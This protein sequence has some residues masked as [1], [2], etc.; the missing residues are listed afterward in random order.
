MHPLVIGLTLS[1][2]A[3]HA[4]WNALLRSG[5]DRL[6]S[7]TVM[8]FATTVA[9]VP[10]ALIL[11]TPLPECWPYIA[12]SA[13]LQ[14][15]YSILLASAYRHGELGQVYPIVRGSVPVLV[16][17]A[18]FLLASQTLSRLGLLGIALVSAGIAS[19]ALGRPP[20]TTKTLLLALATALFVAS[21]V[22]ADGLGVRLAGNVQSYTAWIFLTYGALMPTAFLVLRRRLVLDLRDRETTKA[23]AAGVVS[24]LS[25]GAILAALSLGKL[26]PISALRETSVVFSALLGRIVLGETLTNRRIIAC[27]VVAIGTACL[28]HDA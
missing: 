17:L 12:I 11:P 6:W 28:G 19:L 15:V 20:V 7:V 2:A 10:T 9:A 5:A 21:Y 18:G 3:L 13:L 8:S 27:I 4:I 24:L 26:G 1:A 22:T 14:V 25:Y 23:L 16:T